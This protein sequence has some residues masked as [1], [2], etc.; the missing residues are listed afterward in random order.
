MFAHSSV[1]MLSFHFQV[2]WFWTNLEAKLQFINILYNASYLSFSD[3]LGIQVLIQTSLHS[4][5]SSLPKSHISV[6]FSSESSKR[7]FFLETFRF[8]P[9]FPSQIRHENFVEENSKQLITLKKNLTGC[10][11]VWSFHKLPLTSL[12]FAVRILFIQNPL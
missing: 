10:L 12:G 9:F 2:K 7:G 11:L 8:R 4:F 5:L 6:E 3:F 1:K